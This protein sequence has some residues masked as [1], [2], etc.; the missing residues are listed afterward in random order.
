MFRKLLCFLGFHEWDV[1]I[2]KSSPNGLECNLF[3]DEENKVFR[4]FIAM[5]F[6]CKHCKKRLG[7]R[8]IVATFPAKDIGLGR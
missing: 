5:N 7:S 1:E 8:I 3:Y 2:V 6:Y 4:V